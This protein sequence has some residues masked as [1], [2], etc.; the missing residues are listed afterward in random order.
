LDRAEV[1]VVRCPF[2]SVAGDFS[3]LLFKCDALRWNVPMLCRGLIPDECRLVADAMRSENDEATTDEKLKRE[4]S[5]AETGDKQLDGNDPENQARM[6]FLTGWKFDCL[7]SQFLQQLTGF[8]FGR[9][10]SNPGAS[11]L[12]PGSRW[13]GS[14]INGHLLRT[15]NAFNSG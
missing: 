5:S 11:I 13:S 4:L 10:V 15:H 12:S 2:A 7:V 6:E 3:K 9:I 8:E 14:S 1:W